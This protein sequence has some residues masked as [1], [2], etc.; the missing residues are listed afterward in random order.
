MRVVWVTP[1]MLPE[2]LAKIGRIE[3]GSGGWLGA[4]IPTLRDVDGFEL[5]II[6]V[7]KDAKFSKFNSG[8]ITYHPV[9]SNSGVFRH[10]KELK[11][12]LHN[13]IKT[14]NPVL[15]DFQ[16]LEFCYVKDAKFI[17]G[18]AIP[19]ATLQGM[20]SE[21]SKYYLLGLRAIQILFNLTF[22]DILLFDNL[23]F[24]R[25]YYR[26][27]GHSEIASIRQINYFI[28]RTE[29]DRSVISKNKK[30]FKYYKMIRKVRPLFNKVR[31]SESSLA[32]KT[33]FVS[34]AYAPFKGLHILI[35]AI[36]IVKTHYPEIRVKIAGKNMMTSR[37]LAGISFPGGY[38]KII[39]RM[40]KINQLQENFCFLGSLDEEEMAHQLSISSLYV[41]PSIIENSPNSLLEAQI[42][43]IPVVSSFTGGIDSM[44][45]TSMA[46]LHNPLDHTRLAF[47]ICEALSNR[48]KSISMAARGHR[49]A[50]DRQSAL[51]VGELIN[52][53]RDII[54]DSTSRFDIFNNR[55]NL[56][57][58][59]SS[60]SPSCAVAQQNE[61]IFH[62]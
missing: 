60:I 21:I 10:S 50:V 14:I 20:V 22:R 26:M 2:C 25:L 49:F 7:N 33:I 30:S 31:W 37:T 4:L 53:Y 8:G 38:E 28:G 11:F 58:G 1:S 59:I 55:K 56:L 44:L 62:R 19:V 51:E 5:H 47:N 15:V 52:I 12:K 43:G 9:D 42:V 34:Q 29:W 17:V 16:G 3:K 41:L 39:S 27:R 18:N 13:L 46:Y 32:E 45:D 57:A 36:K 54:A 35:E 24:R 61:D 23:Y 6:I 48:E 40:I